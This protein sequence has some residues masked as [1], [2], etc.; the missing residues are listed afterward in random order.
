[1]LH[2][3]EEGKKHIFRRQDGPD[4]ARPLFCIETPENAE[5]SFHISEDGTLITW[6]RRTKEPVD[7]MVMEAAACF[8]PEH[9]LVPAISYDGNPWGKDHE[10]K[11]LEKDGIPYTYAWHRCAVPGAACSWNQKD[12]LALFGSGRCS[13]SIFLKD[14]RPVYRVIW[15]ETEEP[16]VL[17]ADDWAE[18]YRGHMDPTDTFT[19]YLC[20]GAGIEAERNMLHHAWEQNY[21]SKKPVRAAEE[22]WNLSTAYAKLLYT[23]EEDGFQAFSIG[24]SWDGKKWSKRPDFKY[25]IGWC[26]QNASLA[27]SLLYDCQRRKSCGTEPKDWKESLQI[28]VS[29]LDSWVEKA[30]SNDGFLLTR[31][32]PQ[33]S[34]IDACN[35][36][37]YGVQLFEAYDQARLLGLEKKAWLDAAFEI[38]D[39]AMNRQRLDGGIGMSWNRDGSAHELNGTAGAFLILPLAQAFLRTGEDRYNIAAVRAYS[40]YYREFHN[41]GYGTSGALDTCCI[42]KESVIPLLKGGILMY[43]ATGFDSYLQMAEEAAWYLSTWQWHHSVDYPEDSVLGMMHYDTFGGTAVSTSHLHIDD[44]ALCY[45]PELLELSELTG[46]KEWKERALAVWRNGVQGIS[47]GTLQIMDKAPR[48]AGSCDEAYLHTRWGALH[49]N[50]GG[51]WGD[52]FSVSQWLVAWPC[53]FRLEVLR[54]CDNWNLLN[55]LLQ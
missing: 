45:I 37:T 16:Q 2:I 23:Q 24:F 12:G 50:K 34:L 27:V 3:V 4:G 21:V 44:F 33:D 28:A 42:D 35:L 51:G 17:Y 49:R 22:V 6:T 25:E 48:P 54:K 26:G 30:R 47:D 39:F 36:G 41:T 9:T 46:N 55:G 43:R 38:C 20:P 15:P 52:I 31:Y 29:V 8:E 5:D 11:G 53:A 40:Y 32:D 1:M 7:H 18:A 19:A 14:Q 10:Y 13:G